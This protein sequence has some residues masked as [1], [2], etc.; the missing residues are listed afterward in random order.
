MGTRDET[1]GQLL[2]K[3]PL[4]DHEDGQI[5]AGPTRSLRLLQYSLAFF[6]AAL[7]AFILLPKVPHLQRGDIAAHDIVAP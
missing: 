7:L 5:A 1:I 4:P 2:P 3:M 6:T